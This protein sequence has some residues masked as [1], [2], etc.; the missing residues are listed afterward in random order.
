MPTRALIDEGTTTSINIEAT[1]S[2]DTDT[3]S[4]QQETITDGLGMLLSIHEELSEPSAYAY[5]KL[6]KHQ[7]NIEYFE[8]KL[9]LLTD[10]L[11]DMLK[12]WTRSDDATRSFT[13]TQSTEKEDVCTP[14]NNFFHI[15]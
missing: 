10:E 4:F 9:Q 15:N 1:A 2:I 6:G 12:R 7:F 3:P 14:T 5:N 13:A 8:R 11:V